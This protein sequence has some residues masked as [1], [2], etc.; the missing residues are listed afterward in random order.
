M[1]KGV[2]VKKVGDS[3][4]MDL[5]QGVL[6]GI[7]QACGAESAQLLGSDGLSIKIKGV[8]STQAATI[9]AAIGRGGVP[10]GRLT[11]IHGDEACGK[12]TLA[13]HLVAETQRLGGVA[14]MMDKEYKLDPDYAKNLGVDTNKLI[15]SQPPHL[16]KAFDI[17]DGIIDRAVLLR[18]KGLKAPILI[19]L[20]SMNAAISK[21]QFE[22]KWDDKQY[23][24]QARVYS[25]NLPKLMPKI[26]KEDVA[27]VW[28]SQLRE[29]V[30]LQ[31]GNPNQ[32][33][34]GRAPRFYASLIMEVRRSTA[35][36]EEGKKK[37]NEII[38]ECRK[39]QIA[40][41]F[42]K[43]VAMIRYGKGFDQ[44]RALVVQ[45]IADGIIDK[46]GTW[47]SYGDEKLGQGLKGVKKN[48]TEDMYYEIMKAIELKHGWDR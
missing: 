39:N 40:P 27:M 22:G 10:R 25:Q 24:P 14:V 38:V 7:I 34:G 45:A 48:V 18:E 29:K 4:K 6:E 8:I 13:L 19:V 35:D 26:S 3:D 32:I 46:S 30:G 43:G 36:V 41:P 47:Y 37:G 21:S 1:A 28:I 11:I 44:I 31:F 20:D 33:A 42:E 15:I 16:E 23:A 2:K 9:D 17:W 12:T 5:T